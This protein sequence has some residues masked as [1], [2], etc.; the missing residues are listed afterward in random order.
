MTTPQAVATNSLLTEERK[1]VPIRISV[2]C[3]ASAVAPGR[4]VFLPERLRKLSFPEKF[5]AH[6]PIPPIDTMSLFVGAAETLR[7]V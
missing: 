4:V 7:S 3:T 1:S 5:G 6:R 2:R